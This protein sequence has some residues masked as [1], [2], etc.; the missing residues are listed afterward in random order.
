MGKICENMATTAFVHGSER[1]INVMNEWAQSARAF[2]SVERSAG[3]AVMAVGDVRDWLRQGRDVP[4]NEHL[5]FVEFHDITRARIEILAPRMVVSPLLAHDFDCID[6]AKFL[7]SIEYKG[8][9]RAI[10]STLPNPDMIRCEIAGLCPGLDFDI[11]LTEDHCS[12]R[13]M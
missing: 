3:I 12:L 13:V 9:Y 10:A 1:G 11:M 7:A 6:L 2:A 5:A 8:S 4:L